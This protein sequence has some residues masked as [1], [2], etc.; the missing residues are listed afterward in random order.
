MNP[1]QMQGALMWCRLF[2]WFA[3]NPAVLRLMEYSARWVGVEQRGRWSSLRQVI[4]SSAA[5]LPPLGVMPPM[6]LPWLSHLEV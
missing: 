4:L 5:G 3:E 2:S 1:G 6:P